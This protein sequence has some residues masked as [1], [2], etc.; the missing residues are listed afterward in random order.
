MTKKREKIKIK[1]IEN[2]FMND[3]LKDVKKRMEKEKREK[4]ANKFKGV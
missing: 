2:F 3:V 4:T 1:N